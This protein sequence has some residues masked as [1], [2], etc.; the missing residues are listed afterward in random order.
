MDS[1]AGGEVEFGEAVDGE[2]VDVGAF[3]AAEDAAV[4]GEEEG[5]R[6]GGLLPAV[7]D[8]EIGDVAGEAEV[9]GVAAVEA[10]ESAENPDGAPLAPEPFVGV[11]DFAAVAD[12]GA[13]AA[14]V[15]DGMACPERQD[16]IEEVRAEPRG[17]GGAV[18]GAEVRRGRLDRA[19][20]GRWGTRRGE[21]EDERLERG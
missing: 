7:A 20:S 2:G 8:A 11:E 19:M 10:V 1:V 3:V 18:A 5:P 16:V 12:A 13:E 9:G 21:L 4:L 15:V 17:E 14:V 6:L